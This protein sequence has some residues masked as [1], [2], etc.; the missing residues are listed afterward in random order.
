MTVLTQAVDV[1]EMR[2]RVTEWE[3]ELEEKKPQLQT[4]PYV[5]ETNAALLSKDTP[6]FGE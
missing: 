5:A 1:V 2:R 3:G 6:I 4:L